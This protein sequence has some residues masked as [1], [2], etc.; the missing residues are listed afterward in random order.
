MTLA[1]NQQARPLGPM[2]VEAHRTEGRTRSERREGANGD[3]N[4]VE[5][6]KETMKGT[7]TGIEAGTGTRTGV[8]TR[9]GAGAY[10]G[11][12]TRSGTRRAMGRGSKERSGIRHMAIN[13]SI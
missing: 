12:G 9:T 4:G 11:T 3:G 7:G 5:D 10:T 6:R 2:P 1:G 8:G 13:R